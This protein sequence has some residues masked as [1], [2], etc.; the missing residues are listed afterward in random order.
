MTIKSSLKIALAALVGFSPIIA[1]AGTSGVNTAAHVKAMAPELEGKKVSLDVAFIRINRHAPDDVPY[2]FFW[3]AT[4]DDDEVAKGGVILV[5]A[6][7]EDKDT[8]IRRYG[9][10]IERGN[11]GPETKSLRGTVRLAGRE[12]GPKRAYIDMTADG[13]DLSNSPDSV[14]ND[15][16]I[17][18]ELGSAAGRGP[19]G[20]AGGGFGRPRG[21]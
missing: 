10:N 8:L 21:E 15:S 18:G 17:A 5:V 7:K 11:G 13:V 2:V 20:A 12:G 4:I 1:Q 3:A 6:D 19:R 14:M 16:D 9:T